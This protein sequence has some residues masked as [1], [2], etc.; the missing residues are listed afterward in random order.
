RRLNKK[1]IARYKQYMSSHDHQ[2]SHSKPLALTANQY[3]FSDPQN[4]M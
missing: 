2:V 1:G 3:M 4:Q